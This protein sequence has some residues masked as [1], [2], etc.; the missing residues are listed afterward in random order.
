MKTA[1]VVKIDDGTLRDAELSREEILGQTLL[2]I[3]AL[4]KKYNLSFD[5][6]YNPNMITDDS[7]S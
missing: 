3:A 2:V 1:I 7:A 6:G 4:Y 5:C